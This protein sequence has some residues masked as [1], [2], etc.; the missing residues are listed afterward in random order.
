MRVTAGIAKGRRLRAPST[1]EMRPTADMVRKSIFDILGDAPRDAR[2]LD[3]F[4]GAG[5][6]G[7]E[8][9]S[10]GAREAVFVDSDSAACAAAR[11]NAAA[12]GFADQVRVHRVDVLRY[13]ARAPRTPFDL[14]FLDPPYARGLGF[15]AR[16]LD[17]IAAEDWVRPGG[18]VVVEAASEILEWPAGFRETR[19][20]RFGQTQVG[21]AI[22]DETRADGDLPGD[23]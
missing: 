3:L 11:D 20:R 19:T 18:T 8:A 13:L 22:R 5:T 1:P 15:C 6:L 4:A 10:R 21:M 7:I 12:C 23:V 14:V 2:V 17:R 9:L 16:V